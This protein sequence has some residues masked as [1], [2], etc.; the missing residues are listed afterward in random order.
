MSLRSE[1]LAI[2]KLHHEINSFESSHYNFSD[3]PTVLKDIEQQLHVLGFC[4]PVLTSKREY[5]F[6]PRGKFEVQTHTVSVNE[7]TDSIQ[8]PDLFGIYPVKSKL[9]TSTHYDTSPLFSYYQ[10]KEKRASELEVGNIVV[11]NPRKKHS[12]M[13]LGAATTFML[14]TVRRK[15]NAS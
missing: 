12:L 1:Q 9:I 13:Y 10:S 3:Y 6:I 5:G 14:F 2:S 8:A 11:F 15:R 7:H 4:L